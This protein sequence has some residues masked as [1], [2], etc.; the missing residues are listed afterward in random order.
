MKIR[1]TTMLCLLFGISMAQESATKEVTT[2]IN[3][4]T[5]FIDGAQI[6][7][8]KDVTLASGKTTLK[9]SKLSPYIDAKTV[10]VKTD[11]GVTV[12]AV[13][14][15]QN[16][17]NKLAKSQ[18]LI[19]LETKQQLLNEQIKLELTNSQILQE[20]LSFLHENK[21]ITGSNQSLSV[22]TLKEASEFYG[23]KV[24]QLKLKSLELDKKIEELRKQQDEVDKQIRA[25]TGNNEASSGEVLVEVE[26]T[27]TT[28]ANFE[29]SYTVS[30]AGWFP[31]YDIRANSIDKPIEIVYKANVRQNTKVD[32][33]NVKLR[34]SSSEPNVSGVAPVLQ[35]YRLGYNIEAPRYDKNTNSVA[36]RVTAANSNMPITGASVS[37]SGTTIGTTTD[38]NGYYSL[39][40]PVNATKL[41]FS[42]IGFNSQT[43][44]N[45]YSSTINIA[46]Q[47]QQMN[48]TMAYSVASRNRS[49][50]SQPASS[51]MESDLVL[52][53]AEE[54][55]A[56]MEN[57]NAEVSV[58]AQNQ[59]TLDFEITKPYS[60][61]SDNKSTAVDMVKYNLPASYQYYS[62]PKIEKSAFLLANIVDWEKYNLLEGEANIFFE[63]TFVGKSLLDV[64]SAT[65]TLQISLGH[66]KSISISREKTKDYTNKQVIGTKKEESR[67]W[68]TTVK[69]N[70]QQPISLMILDQVPVSTNQD[71]EVSVGK[72]S[73]AKLNPAT[74][75]AKWEFTLD[76]SSKRELELNYTVKYPKNKKLIIE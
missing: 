58:Q 4:V 8:K 70:K 51:N 1:L 73:G 20:E 57:L 64:R 65:D 10:Q 43:I 62:V 38:N 42:H 74:G 11:N 15:Q 32:W 6:T 7:R 35:V 27:A 61:T 31:S 67:C 21:V 23:A 40:L 34:F 71:I 72:T 25:I 47:P 46:L 28:T 54:G 56:D 60:I 13:H 45:I 24:K 44:N 52:E 49:K 76:P 68:K 29:L 33:K 75:E 17:L 2:E 50:Q 3:E 41:T 22:T 37:V 66:D 26:T 36:G 12:K 16:Y 59:T 63:G 5:V 69:N 53:F 55:H 19:N 9:F 14:H 18:E 39:M 30:N 48:K